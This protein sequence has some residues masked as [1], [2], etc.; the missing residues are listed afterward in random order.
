MNAMN[1]HTAEKL[2]LEMNE[3]EAAF[4]AVPGGDSAQ[5]IQK[6]NAALPRLQ[7]LAQDLTK[8]AL[9]KSVE[10]D[11]AELFAKGAAAASLNGHL[12]AVLARKIKEQ[13]GGSSMTQVS[14]YKL[15]DIWGRNLASRAL[16][17]QLATE[18]GEG[19]ASMTRDKLK[20]SLQVLFEAL[21][22]DFD[23]IVVELGKKDSFVRFAPL[24]DM[25]ENLLK[26]AVAAGLSGAILKE[27][28]QLGL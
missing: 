11:L 3:L 23:M 9:A 10:L 26:S 12:Y 14:A 19:H 28:D 15:V 22:D 16:C 6:L 1:T 7:A 20:A 4:S 18:V 17:L 24:A 25:M 5:V 27:I 8:S 2:G 13:S 21:Q